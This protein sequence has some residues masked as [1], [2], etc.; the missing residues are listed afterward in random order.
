MAMNMGGHRGRNSMKL[1]GSLR[2]DGVLSWDD[3]TA[4]VHYQLDL[5]EGRDRRSGSGVLDGELADLEARE[6]P[7]RLRLA[8]GF[9]IEIVLVQVD[10]DG[11]M[12]EARSE[13][14]SISHG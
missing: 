6:E 3:R 12:F 8:D 9:E 2:G 13:L 11:A 7:A 1:L 4:A 5:F 10:E 14:P